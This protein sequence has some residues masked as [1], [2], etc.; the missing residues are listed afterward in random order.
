MEWYIKVLKNYAVFNGRARRKEYW[1]FFLVNL[2][3]SMAFGFI[4]G[5]IGAMLG[6]TPIQSQMFIQLY[7]LAVLIS[8]LAVGV[9]RMHDSG[10]S[11]WWIIAPFINLIFL[12]YDSQP[13]TNE[14]GPNPKANEANA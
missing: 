11:G 13:S 14:Y 8:S 12:C 3:M 9:R 6:A 7:S 4:V 10:H 2:L 5:F 1:M